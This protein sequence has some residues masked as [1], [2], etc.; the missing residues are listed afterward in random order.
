LTV[1]HAGALTN[2]VGNGLAPAFERD[3]GIPVRAVRG[4]SVALADGIKDGSKVGDIFMSA[5]AEVNAQLMGAAN[6]DWVRWFVVFARNAVVLAFS[7]RGRFTAEF[8]RA[9]RGE[10]PWYEALGQPGLRLRRNDPDSDPLG[11]YTVLVCQLAEWHY[12]LPGLQERLLGA[13]RNPEQVGAPDLAGLRAGD[14]DAVFLYQTAAQD[15][16]LPFLR[17]PAAIN[18]GEPDLAAEYARASHTTANGRVFRGV[19]IRFSATMLARTAQADAAQR[20]LTYLL[21]PAG[22]ELV[23]AYY[24]LPSP[25]LVGGDEAAVP[26]TVRP[27]IQDRYPG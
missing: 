17:L 25:V 16:G 14:L 15:S 7:P 26:E 24:F 8:E 2:L 19:P 6:G 23:R 13:P 9:R 3:T 4:H 20:F 1:L 27:F 18:L 11:Y 22:Q 5:D 21:L 10:L 12:G